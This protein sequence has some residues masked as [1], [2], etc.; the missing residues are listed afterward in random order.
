MEFMRFWALSRRIVLYVIDG[1][2]L[3]KTRFSVPNPI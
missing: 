2:D 1:Q 3:G